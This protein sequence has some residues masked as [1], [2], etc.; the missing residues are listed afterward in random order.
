LT[1]APRLGREYAHGPDARAGARIALTARDIGATVY[2]A[3]A[4][5]FDAILAVRDLSLEV[6]RP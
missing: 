4:S 3:D 6:V 1:A 5:D 2:T